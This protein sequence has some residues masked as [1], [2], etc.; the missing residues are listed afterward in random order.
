MKHN[1]KCR[2]CGKPSELKN[3]ACVCGIPHVISAYHDKINCEA[4]K[5]G[6]R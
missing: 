5:K 4:C 6:M 3:K 1:W 2:D